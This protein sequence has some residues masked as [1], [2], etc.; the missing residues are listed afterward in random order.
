MKSDQAAQFVGFFSILFGVITFYAGIT[1][2]VNY[3]L[4]ALGVLLTVFGFIVATISKNREKKEKP[5]MIVLLVF[6]C[7]LELFSI[8][9]LF[10]FYFM[11]VVAFVSGQIF[12]LIPLILSIKYFKKAKEEIIE[13]KKYGESPDFFEALEKIKEKENEEDK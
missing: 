4:I 5:F 10:N 2:Y 1:W 6:F 8:S 12:F 3:F 11:N 7:L 13:K 9:L